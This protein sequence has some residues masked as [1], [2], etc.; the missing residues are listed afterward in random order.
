MKTRSTNLAAGV[1]SLALVGGFAFVSRQGRVTQRV[2]RLISQ[3]VTTYPAADSGTTG[4]A[5]KFETG[6]DSNPIG[7]QIVL[8][9]LPPENRPPPEPESDEDP[10]VYQVVDARGRVY[11]E[12]TYS[13]DSK[14][15]TI[16]IP[17]TYGRPV[18]RPRLL[19]FLNEE[20]CG[21]VDLPPFPQPRTQPL[22]ARKDP[23]MAAFHRTGILPGIGRPKPYIVIRALEE[24]PDDELWE[25]E[26]VRTNLRAGGNR[27]NLR[28]T[29]ESREAIFNRD[30]SEDVQALRLR[31]ARF[32]RSIV[33]E[34]VTMPGPNLKMVDGKATFDL[35]KPVPIPNRMGFGVSLKALP[36]STANTHPYLAELSLATD[37]RHWMPQSPTRDT[38]L[39]EGGYIALPGGK[40]TEHTARVFVDLISPRPEELGLAGIR[41]WSDF[42][43]SFDAKTPRKV[44]E[45]PVTFRF[46]VGKTAW[47]PLGQFEVTI[48]VET[49][50]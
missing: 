43:P 20:L 37:Q 25:V 41:P 18:E 12:P 19:A 40:P 28:I 10:I 39:G 1:V 33:S 24:I 50:G 45:G 22:E 16:Y 13:I 2:P 44:R 23:R 15:V 30:Y 6:S 48:P 49:A 27:A 34:E 8:T 36:R 31:I 3:S 47:Q 42:G 46:R 5:S 4:P 26:L 17:A 21:S 29:A 11:G 14:P 38:L 7:G 32:R 35:P 9:F